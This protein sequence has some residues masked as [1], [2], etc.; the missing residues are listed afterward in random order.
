M[1]GDENIIIETTFLRGRDEISS[2]CR[3]SWR[4]IKKW[5]KDDGFPAVKKDHIWESDA[6]LI[7]EWRREQINKTKKKALVKNTGNKTG[8]K[9]LRARQKSN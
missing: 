4:I 3:R 1:V 5:I 8:K 6:G 7:K 2:H 9:A